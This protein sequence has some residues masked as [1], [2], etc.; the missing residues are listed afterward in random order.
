VLTRLFELGAKLQMYFELQ[1]ELSCSDFSKSNDSMLK[2]A[3]LADIFSHLNGLNIRV[4]GRDKN[5]LL[6]GV[7]II[8]SIK[9][10]TSE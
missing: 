7:N 8:L 9:N 1:E 6:V 10:Y 5:I 3:Y 2:L 4:Q